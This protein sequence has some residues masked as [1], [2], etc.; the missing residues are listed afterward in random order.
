MGRQCAR[1]ARRVNVAAHAAF[2]MVPR[3][4]S[5][6]VASARLPGLH[7]C[8][9]M[10][11]RRVRPMRSRTPVARP[12]DPEAGASGPHLIGEGLIRTVDTAVAASRSFIVRV[13]AML[14]FGLREPKK[15]SPKFRSISR[16]RKIRMR[17]G[18]S[19]SLFERFPEKPYR[20]HWR[21][22]HRLRARGEAA[23]ATAFAYL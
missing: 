18:G 8:A 9:A 16:S 2:A 3:Y 22:Y 23:G 20:M 4:A 5:S 12:L 14:R 19:A 15:E 13:S 21:T 7:G 1:L 6:G 10:C 11:A 17:P